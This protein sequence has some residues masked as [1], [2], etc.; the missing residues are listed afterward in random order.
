MMDFR[1]FGAVGL[2]VALVGFC[3]C[4]TNGGGA[5]Q[6]QDMVVGSTITV[7]VV[8]PSIERLKGAVIQAATHRR[9]VP[10]VIDAQTVRCTLMKRAHRVVVDVR[11]E[12]AAAYTIICREC[13]VSK[14]KYAQWM[15]NLQRSIAK[16]ACR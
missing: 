2:I 13:T 1:R 14:N 9:Y 12:S 6:P 4:G 8:S 5:E 15:M 16:L 3:G 7:S 11:M 10:E